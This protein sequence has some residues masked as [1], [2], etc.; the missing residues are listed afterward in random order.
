MLEALEEGNN[1]A[2]WLVD[3]TTQADRQGRC[4]IFPCA[5]RCHTLCAKPPAEQFRHCGDGAYH[6][7]LCLMPLLMLLM[8]ASTSSSSSAAGC[9]EAIH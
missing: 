4:S 7:G 2:E 5:K 1:E 6:H 9:M 3:L 8:D